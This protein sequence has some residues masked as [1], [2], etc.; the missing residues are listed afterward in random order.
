MG[1]RYVLDYFCSQMKSGSG[2]SVTSVPRFS[3]DVT[4][5]QATKLSILLRFNFHDVNSS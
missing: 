3:H 5:I 2:K 4:K 1:Y